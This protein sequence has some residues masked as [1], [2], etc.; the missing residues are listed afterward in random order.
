MIV[1]THLLTIREVA[2][3]LRQSERTVR[4]KVADGTLPAVRIG[5]GPRAP[6][7]VDGGELERW[8]E[9]HHLEPK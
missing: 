7:R 9:A 8:I 4:G 1:Q 3:M 6:F 5:S 2:A